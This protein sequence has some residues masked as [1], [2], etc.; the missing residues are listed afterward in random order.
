MAATA[1]PVLPY[2]RSS[3]KVHVS[4]TAPVVGNVADGMTLVNDGATVVDVHN[5]NSGSTDHDVTFNPLTVVE[6]HTV[7]D[8]QTVVH[9]TTDGFGPFPVAIYGT[10]MHIDAAHAELTFIAR[11]IPRV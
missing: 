9:A 4:A 10:L 1:I 8:P 5:T 3:N 11:R 7:D 6:G 2:G